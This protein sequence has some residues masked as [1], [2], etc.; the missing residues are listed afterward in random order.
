ML[1]VVPSSLGSGGLEKRA[2][3]VGVSAESLRVTFWR[4][5][6]GEGVNTA[7]VPHSSKLHLFQD[8]TH[9]QMSA[10]GVIDTHVV[11]ASQQ[12]A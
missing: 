8:V 1:R 5:K 7:A 3:T 11:S 10:T 9:Q 12:N 6:T 4:K 2:G